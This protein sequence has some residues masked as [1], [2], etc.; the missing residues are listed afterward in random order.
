MIS[1]RSI[2]AALGAST[3]PSLSM[4]EPESRAESNWKAVSRKRTGDVALADPPVLDLSMTLAH[5]AQSKCDVV[6]VHNDRIAFRSIVG[7]SWREDVKDK[8][9]ITVA[10]ETRSK[11]DEDSRIEVILDGSSYLVPPESVPA[12]VKTIEVGIGSLV[13]QWEC[14]IS[15]F[16]YA[17]LVR[18]ERLAIRTMDGTFCITKQ[19][20]ELLR[21]L[22]FWS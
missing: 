3:L 1:R 11:C 18:R 16:Y 20:H 2:L 8:E 4:A 22:Y 9:G 14:V 12:K 10:V 17:A 6:S 13:Y 15:R 21:E 19:A 5:D 7:A